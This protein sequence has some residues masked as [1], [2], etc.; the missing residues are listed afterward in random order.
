MTMYRTA[1]RVLSSLGYREDCSHL[2]HFK[3]ILPIY[4]G[5]CYLTY[6]PDVLGRNI[7]DKVE[8]S[9]HWKQIW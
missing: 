8:S 3:F 1:L 5:K 9:C 6:V 7:V 4:S 2:D